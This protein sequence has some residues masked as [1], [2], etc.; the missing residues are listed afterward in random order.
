[1]RT[2]WTE[3]VGLLVLGL[4]IVLL[5]NALGITRVST[6]DF[7]AGVLAVL[8][9]LIGV[10]LLRRSRKARKEPLRDVF[11]GNLRLEEPGWEVTDTTFQLGIGQVFVDLTRAHI[12]E[13][14]H[15]LRFDGLVGQVH[16]VAPLEVSLSAQGRVTIGALAILGERAEGF[17]RYLAT[18]SPDYA[19][20][21]RRLKIEASLLVGEIRVEHQP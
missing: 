14:E 7:V 8:L 21:P 4:G 5:L 2:L 17:G 19:S 12:R 3:V 13:G 10:H 11:L 1:M 6:G 15:T 16:V 20:T 18:S 9:I